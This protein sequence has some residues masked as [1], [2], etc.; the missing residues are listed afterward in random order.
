MSGTFSAARD[1]PPPEASGA[2]AAAAIPPA[3]P[4]APPVAPHHAAGPPPAPSPP[5]RPCM[6]HMPSRHLRTQSRAKTP[7]CCAAHAPA[8]RQQMMSGS[9]STT[10]RRMRRSCWVRRQEGRR[11]PARAG[12]AAEPG[13]ALGACDGV[14]RGSRGHGAWNP[15]A[16]VGASQGASSD[17]VELFIIIKLR[18]KIYIYIY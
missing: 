14:G 16:C 17:G 18:P 15:C 5:T 4:A 8:A 13:A 9:S 3:P 12:A 10:A 6:Q 7:W 11:P 2:A 1:T